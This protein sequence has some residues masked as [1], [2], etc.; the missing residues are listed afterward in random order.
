MQL[1]IHCSPA[2]PVWLLSVD[3]GAPHTPISRLPRPV[4]E[5]AGRDGQ[6][7]A[8]G[9][10]VAPLLYPQA[11]TN[12]QVFV[13]L[14]HPGRVP[15]A[16]LIKAKTIKIS[17]VM[18]T[19]TVPPRRKALA[20]SGLGPRHRAVPLCGNATLHPGGMSLLC[21]EGAP[22]QVVAVPPQFAGVIHSQAQGVSAR[23]LQE[24]ILSLLNNGAICVIPPAVSEQFLLQVFSGP[25]T[26]EGAV[27]V[28]SWIY[29]F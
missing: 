2:P 10:A 21:Q 13:S 18:V 17:S 9:S 23:V 28:L 1:D 4:P 11:R 16:Q 6:L 3:P 12:T 8:E 14:P 27:F 19:P 5:Q 7:T 22:P 26:G 25:Q 24:E 15:R 20:F 29:V